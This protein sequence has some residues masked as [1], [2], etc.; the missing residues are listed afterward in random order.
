MRPTATS[1][2]A[3]DRQAFP[4]AVARSAWRYGPLT[5]PRSRPGWCRPR[6][7]REFSPAR[8]G[9]PHCRL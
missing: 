8:R 4:P 7:G 1:A 5:E 3:G 9:W 2:R 6:H